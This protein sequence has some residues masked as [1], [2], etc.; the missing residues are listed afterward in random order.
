[1]GVKCLTIHTYLFA[2]NVFEVL[3]M[4]IH[5]CFSGSQDNL[6][7]IGRNPDK[8]VA[9]HV[10]SREPVITQSP[11]V[12]AQENRNSTSVI[13]ILAEAQ[14]DEPI[15]RYTLMILKLYV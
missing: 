2:L 8:Q 4:S 14:N 13:N 10:G 7:F 3:K 9:V 1:M 12:I 5:C 6:N 11:R 15:G